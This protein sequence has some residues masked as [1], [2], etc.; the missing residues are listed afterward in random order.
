[1]EE[2]RQQF[3]QPKS[4]AQ[5]SARADSKSSAELMTDTDF[6]TFRFDG[7]GLKPISDHT[8]VS[9]VISANEDNNFRVFSWN[10]MTK[11]HNDS[12]IDGPKFSN[13]PYNF[14]ESDK[15][16]QA[17]SAKQMHYLLQHMSDEE[18][19]PDFI[20]LQEAN[21]SIIKCHYDK[22]KHRME[23]DGIDEKFLT[24]A[25]SLGYELLYNERSKNLVTLY[26]ARK[27]KLTDQAFNI[28]DS[29]GRNTLQITTFT[30]NKTQQLLAVG[31][32][33]LEYGA[34]NLGDALKA[35]Q[36]N[37]IKS[38]IPLVMIGDANHFPKSPL[39]EEEGSLSGMIAN[40]E[41]A[42]TFC[43]GNFGGKPN[44]RFPTV[45]HQNSQGFITKNPKAY[46]GV[47]ISPGSDSEIIAIE[48]A[49]LGF[50]QD[51]NTIFFRV[52]EN[53]T[54]YISKKGRPYSNDEAKMLAQ[55][56]ALSL[57]L[58]PAPALVQQQ[59]ADEEKSDDDS[60]EAASASPD[61]GVDIL[62][63]RSSYAAAAKPENAPK[64]TLEKYQ[65]P[66]K[67]V[68]ANQKIAQSPSATKLGNYRSGDII[69]QTKEALEFYIT[70]AKE[71]LFF[72]RRSSGKY[73]I[74][75]KANQT[76][77]SETY[78]FNFS[79]QD[80]IEI[81]VSIRKQV[82]GG[83]SD[84]VIKVGGKEEGA[85]FYGKDSPTNRHLKHE[86]YTL[87]QRNNSALYKDIA[88]MITHFRE[89]NS[90]LAWQRQ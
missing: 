52:C 64:R 39:A 20:A 61:N 18:A 74:H 8:P 23:F 62:E 24:Q 7:L 79:N 81:S 33:H 12:G 45:Y 72:R 17:R 89:K 28:P 9:Y 60:L 80:K 26:N 85:V 2:T 56:Q 54:P 34:F 31:N 69:D 10:M 22:T 53:K 29:H 76:I 6:L 19:G 43:A 86:L 32:F 42:T 63:A 58:P 38:D 87:N 15:M 57:D 49:R 3:K 67:R 68:Q 55:D 65:I 90:Q 73:N 4:R 14:Q 66:Q 88:E 48:D 51:S 11:C 82:E 46:D 50:A 83:F 5:A 21:G 70:N 71:E 44:Y 36:D 35:I 30:N 13:N 16:F 77:G 41:S 40:K 84:P 25:K 1:M 78:Y 27:F 47:F 59:K 37:F 75:C